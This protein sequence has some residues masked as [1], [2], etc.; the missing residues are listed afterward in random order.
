MELLLLVLIT[1]PKLLKDFI[2]TKIRWYESIKHSS[3]WQSRLLR[4]RRIYHPM[5]PDIYIPIPVIILPGKHLLV[6]SMVY[7][8]ISRFILPLF[9]IS[10]RLQIDIRMNFDPVAKTWGS[11][12]GQS[13]LAIDKTNDNSKWIRFALPLAI[14][15]QPENDVQWFHAFMPRFDA[16]SAINGL[17]RSCYRSQLRLLPTIVGV[18]ILPTE[19][20]N[21]SVRIS[22]LAAFR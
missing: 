17:R 10:G 14:Q 21:I 2:T 4:R 13:S 6:A 18:L 12:M 11:S 1:T 19:G 3:H 8:I 7:W 15:L 20:K 22:S 5:D 16:N 9:N